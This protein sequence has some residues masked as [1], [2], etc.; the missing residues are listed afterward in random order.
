MGTNA[1]TQTL[2]T[3]LGQLTDLTSFDFDGNSLDCGIPTELSATVYYAYWFPNADDAY[4]ACVATTTW[5]LA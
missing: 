5:R 4:A 1:L 3:E 2:P